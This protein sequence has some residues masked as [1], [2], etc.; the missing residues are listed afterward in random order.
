M[1][2]FKMIDPPDY[3]SMSIKKIEE[4]IKDLEKQLPDENV[5]EIIKEGKEIIEIKLKHES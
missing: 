5:E 1:V 4:Y 3:F 2:I